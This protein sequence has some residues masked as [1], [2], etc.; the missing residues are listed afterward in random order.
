MAWLAQ[1]PAETETEHEVQ[2]LSRTSMISNHLS[3]EQ[4]SWL[5]MPVSS[6]GFRFQAWPGT[7]AKALAC[8]MHTRANSEQQDDST[9]VSVTIT[10]I[11]LGHNDEH[12]LSLGWSDTSVTPRS[13]KRTISR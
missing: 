4:V 11:I 1:A 13:K 6:D 8:L 5:E 2:V 12:R 9:S 7:F 10:T 3:Q